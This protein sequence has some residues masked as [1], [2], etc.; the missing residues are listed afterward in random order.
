MALTLG[1]SSTSKSSAHWPVNNVTGRD[2]S[3]DCWPGNSAKRHVEVKRVMQTKGT[4]FTGCL[5]AFTVD[6]YSS[7]ASIQPTHG[8]S[9]RQNSFLGLFHRPHHHQLRVCQPHDFVRG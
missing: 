4:Q 6:N 5:C 7:V 8:Q 9:S 2:I 3:G 1:A